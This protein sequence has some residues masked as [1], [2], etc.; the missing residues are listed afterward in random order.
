MNRLQKSKTARRLNARGGREKW[1]AQESSASEGL[2]AAWQLG[3]LASGLAFGSLAAAL[4]KSMPGSPVDL[5]R[6]CI[7]ASIIPAKVFNSLQIAGDRAGD[8]WF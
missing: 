3:S 5:C 7:L 2:A 6:F 1:V 8:S 4:A